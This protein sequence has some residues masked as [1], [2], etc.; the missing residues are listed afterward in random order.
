MA[1]GLAH[2]GEDRIGSVVDAEGGRIGSAALGFARGSAVLGDCRT[3]RRSAGVD[4]DRY[5][6]AHPGVS[7][8]RTRANNASSPA[9]A[10]APRTRGARAP[11]TWGSPAGRS[12]SVS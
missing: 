10:I 7:S 12:R 5:H 8:A 4:A 9:G 6:I 2:D 11:V 3:R 1:Q